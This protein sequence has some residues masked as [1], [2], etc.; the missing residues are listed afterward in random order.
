MFKAIGVALV[1]YVSYAAI[2]GSVLAKSGARGRLVLREETP[3][4]FWAV[5]LV[6][7]GLSL[8]LIFVF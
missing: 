8:A 4:Y 3:G 2:T 7:A 5:I 1:I 6:Y